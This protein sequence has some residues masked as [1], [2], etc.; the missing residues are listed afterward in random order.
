MK[1]NLVCDLSLDLSL[2]SKVFY[3]EDCP[4]QSDRVPPLSARTSISEQSAPK[5][6]PASMEATELS[7]VS[8]QP[9]WSAIQVFCFMPNFPV[10][11]PF[12][13]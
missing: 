1:N 6:V 7:G 9:E 10:P 8:S 4:W 3:D 13:Q 12:C 11:Y 2:L 5:A